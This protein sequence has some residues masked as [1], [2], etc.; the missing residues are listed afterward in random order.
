[1]ALPPNHATAPTTSGR[2]TPAGPEPSA[3]PRTVGRLALAAALA[4][5]GIGHLTVS[6]EEFQAQ[7][8]PW[9]PL[10]PDVV[11]LASGVV[12]IA[13]AAALALAPRKHRWLVGWVVAAFFVAIFPGNISQYVTGTDGFGLDTDRARALR[14]PFQPVLVLWA[15][16]STGAWRTWRA[17]RT[18]AG[19][20]SR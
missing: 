15:L 9:V 4:T 19:D 1:M 11:V 6:R 20:A 8:P 14:L 7:V 10:D 17:R 3:V 12:E 16:W 5:A 2:T 18:A 13:L